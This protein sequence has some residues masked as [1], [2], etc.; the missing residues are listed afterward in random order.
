M[1]IIV[2]DLQGAAIKKLLTVHLENAHKLSPPGS[3]FA[4]DIE[5]LRA[6]EL[7]FWTIWQD[8]ELLGC[9][10]LNEIS[11]TLGEIK[12]MH[13]FGKYRGKGV[14]SSLVKHLLNEAKKR[15][16]QNISLETGT[17][18]DYAAAHALYRKFGFIDCCAF[19]DYTKPNTDNSHSVFMTLSLTDHH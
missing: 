7:T 9:G 1:H 15:Q 14:A 11:S 2:D 6:P 5:A 10:A 18:P 4:L 17:L 8:E 13:T 16:Y 19:G 3:V 12:S